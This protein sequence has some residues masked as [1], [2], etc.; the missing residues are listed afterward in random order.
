M[1]TLFSPDFPQAEAESINIRKNDFAE[2]NLMK[3]LN[4]MLSP[5][6]RY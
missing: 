5:V 4:I 2:D 6:T 3:Y 1:A